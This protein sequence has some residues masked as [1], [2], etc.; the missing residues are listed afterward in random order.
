[1][2]KKNKVEEKIV[3][4]LYHSNKIEEI[5]IDREEYYE[6]IFSIFPEI[7]GHALALEYILRHYKEE[8]SIKHIL[9][10]HELL[11]KGL[12]EDKYCGK[13][14]DIPVYIGGHEALHPVAI[15]NAMDNFI[16]KCNNIKLNAKVIWE[17]HNNFERVHPYVDGNGRTGRLILQ[18][19]RLHIGLSLLIISSEHEERYAYYA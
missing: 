18:Y 8:I 14:R 11:T 2:F 9:K 3:D 16:Y 10:I 12:V 7:S 4:F 17:L 5:D 6:T 13:F 19:L 15:K 1:M